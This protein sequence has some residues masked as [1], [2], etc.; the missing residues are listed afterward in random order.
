MPLRWFRIRNIGYVGL[1]VVSGGKDTKCLS[2]KAGIV[3]S[4]VPGVAVA[5]LREITHP[6]VNVTAIRPVGG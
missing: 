3:A 5:R 2:A 1:S 6:I 4:V